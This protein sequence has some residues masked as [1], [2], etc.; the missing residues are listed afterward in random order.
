MRILSGKREKR[1]RRKI[2]G[3]SERER[4]SDRNMMMVN[5]VATNRTRRKSHVNNLRE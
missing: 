5:L 1:R 2:H 3:E 4:E